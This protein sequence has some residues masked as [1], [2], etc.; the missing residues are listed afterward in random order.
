MS[1]KREMER[2]KIKK[3]VVPMQVPNIGQQQPFDIAEA[4]MQTCKEC[5][6]EFF[7]IVYKIGVISKLAPKNSTG[8]NVLIKG[9]AYIC[10]DCGWEFEK[11]A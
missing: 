10:H 8:K 9:E 1:L 7:D 4:D 11:G 2:K 6:S 5:G 3:K